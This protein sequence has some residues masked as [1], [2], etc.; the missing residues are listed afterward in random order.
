MDKLRI[1]NANQTLCVLIH[2]RN[3]V[4]SVKLV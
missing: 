2:I 3:E 4:G 1:F